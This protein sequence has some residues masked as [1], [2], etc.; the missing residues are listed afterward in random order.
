MNSDNLVNSADH[1]TTIENEYLF[2]SSL[3]EGY[4]KKKEY[5]TI[6]FYATV[7][8]KDSLHFIEGH[9]AN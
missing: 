6:N 3:P 9:H 1:C 4:L 8:F 5:I 7:Y 2:S